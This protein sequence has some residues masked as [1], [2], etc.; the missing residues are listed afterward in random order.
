MPDLVGRFWVLHAFDVAR[1]ISLPA[2]R[3]AL[4]TQEVPRSRRR[5]WP[6]LF[7]LEERPLVWSPPPLDISVGGELMSFQ[8]RAIIY[9][10]GSVTVSLGRPM[11]GPIETWRDLSVALGGTPELSGLAGD[12]LAQFLAR[13]AGAIRDQRVAD[14]TEQ[15]TVFQIDGVEGPAG[16]WLKQHALTVAQILRGEVAA[17][18]RDEIDE[19]LARRLSYAS[20]DAIAIDGAAALLID[21]AFEDTLA[22]LDFANC[23]RLSM[24]V[25][26]DDLDRTVVQAGEVIRGSSWRLRLRS[27]VRPW[28]RDVRRLTQL[29]FDAAAEFEAVENAIKLTGDHYLARVY[30][31]AVERFDLPLFHEAI[32]RKLA[33]LWSIQRVFLDQASTRRSELLEVIIIVLILVEIL[34][35][36]R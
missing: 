29:T 1:E 31:L 5:E 19:A 25:L 16:Q 12:V 10:F 26:D 36:F 28:G 32:A 9:D 30:R 33:S 4:E 3:A 6:H 35:A 23:E 15:Y 24:R 22:V 34:Q 14:V 11:S 27:L 2:C 17:L 7:G 21:R 13:A 18:A 8:P 20:E